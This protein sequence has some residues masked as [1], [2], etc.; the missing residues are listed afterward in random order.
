MRDLRAISHSARI[1]RCGR[2][3]IAGLF[4][5]ALAPQSSADIL[6]AYQDYEQTPWNDAAWNVEV[7]HAG[8]LPAS[9]A[10]IDGFA[11]EQ[12]SGAACMSTESVTTELAGC[13]VADTLNLNDTLFAKDIQS[14]VTALPQPADVEIPTGQ[15]ASST[16]SFPISFSLWLLAGVV[17]ALALFRTQRIVGG[18]YL[19]RSRRR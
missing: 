9:N 12:N 10:Q 19:R 13:D 14:L 2:L 18:R 6:T 15:P 8:V 16:A 3:S 11:V 7:T 4:L 1:L 5:V 17:A